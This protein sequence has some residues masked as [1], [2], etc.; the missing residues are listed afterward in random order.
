M[1]LEQF[2]EQLTMLMERHHAQDFDVMV[3]EVQL[4]CYG[5]I[6]YEGIVPLTGDHF[7]LDLDK[8][9]AFVDCESDELENR[10]ALLSKFV[11]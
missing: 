11:R 5:N 7:C 2:I 4:D 1:K 6:M 9:V 10:D 8:E 3:R